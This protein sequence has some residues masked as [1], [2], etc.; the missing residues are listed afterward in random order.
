MTTPELLSFIR[1]QLAKGS[2]K[3]SIKAILMGAGWEVSDISEAFN[4]IEPA[5]VEIPHVATPISNPVTPTMSPNTVSKVDMT[6]FMTPHVQQPVASPISVGAMPSNPMPEVHPKKSHAMLLMMA[7]IVLLL[8]GGGGAFAYYSGYFESPV[9]VMAQT[10]KN[11]QNSKSAKFDMTMSLKTRLNDPAKNP[12]SFF[13]FDFSNIVMQVKGSSENNDNNEKADLVMSFNVGN[14]EASLQVKVLNKVLYTSLLKAPTFGLA[15]LTAYQNKW[16]FIKQDDQNDTSTNMIP[17]VGTGKSIYDKLTEEEKKTIYA[18]GE[19]ANFITALKKNGSDSLEGVA[20][21]RYT[22]DLDKAGILD[23]LLQVKNFL[24]TLANRDS[25][26]S[27]YSNYDFG[28]ISKT[29]EK[30]KNFQ[31]EVWI[32]KKDKLPRKVTI[33]FSTDMT[34]GDAVIGSVDINMF[35]LLSDW[36]MPV[37]VEAPVDA[38][39]FKSLINSQLEQAQAK[40]RD[41]SVKAYLSNMRAQA[42]LYWDRNGINGYKGFCKSTGTYGAMS[43]INSLNE[44]TKPNITT[45]KDAKDNYIIYSPVSDNT[46]WC[47]DS[48]GSFLNLT[49]SPKSFICK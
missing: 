10:S 19:K 39:D 9:A 37:K 27:V 25:Y 48:T 12:T 31:G 47:V 29:L 14:I 45:C 16:F 4:I 22:F 46:F 40:S 41:A 18:I 1:A 32:G 44:V 21:N 20:T 23:Y 34:N 30:V 33:N 49:Q 2:S 43:S 8:V 28:D 11:L 36:N 26:F 15:D 3:D 35:A 42:E 13:G 17:V 7:V 6:P 38:V 24:T 5:H